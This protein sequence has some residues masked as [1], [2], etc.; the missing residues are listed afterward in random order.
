MTGLYNLL[1]SNYSGLGACIPASAIGTGWIQS[2]TDVAVL[3]A[4]SG[5][6][7]AT[8]PVTACD[9]EWGAAVADQV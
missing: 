4:V 3:S 6:G 2:T 5:T 8:Q 7:G 1:A 9:S